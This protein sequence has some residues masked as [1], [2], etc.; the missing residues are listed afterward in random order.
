MNP[1]AAHPDEPGPVTGTVTRLARQSRRPDRVSVFLDGRFAFGLAADVVV[2]LGLG[3]GSVV[4]E[5]EYARIQRA[6]SQFDARQAALALLSRRPMTEAEL[7]RKL[8]GKAYDPDVAAQVVARLRE[9]GYVNDAE[10]AAAYAVSRSRARGYGPRRILLEL[11]HRGIA[12]D[13]ARQA[14]ET[15]KEGTDSAA[16]ALEAARRAWPRLA[17]ETDRRKRTARLYGYLA[18]RGFDHDDILAAVTELEG[19]G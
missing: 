1:D 4:D 6:G 17:R 14:V 19:A 9:I 3:K 18:R 2:S 15:L 5:T 7:H 11:R 12:E 10:Y 16:S 13:L 8:V